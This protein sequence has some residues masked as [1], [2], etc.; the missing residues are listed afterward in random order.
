MIE[1][2]KANPQQQDNTFAS[3]APKIF[4]E[5]CRID[6]NKDADVIHNFVRGLSPY[7]AAWTVHNDKQIKIFRSKKSEFTN[8]NSEINAG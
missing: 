6:W 2:G 3:P 8:Q 1:L 5:T 7:P 4:K